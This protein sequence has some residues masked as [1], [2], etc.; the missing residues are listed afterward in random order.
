MVALD[1][2]TLLSGGVKYIALERPSNSNWSRSFTAS[3]SSCAYCAHSIEAEVYCWG[4]YF[5]GTP[6]FAGD[7]LVH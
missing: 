2:N 6:P 4:C 5:S 3:S 1:G 7:T